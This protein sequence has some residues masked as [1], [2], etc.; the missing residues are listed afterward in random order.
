MSLSKQLCALPFKWTT[1]TSFK[2]KWHFRENE[3]SFHFFLIFLLSFL[4]LPLL[5]LMLLPVLLLLLPVLLL[6]P[7][8]LLSLLLLR[9]SST[10]SRA[11]QCQKLPI[12]AA[13]TEMVC[14]HSSVKNMFK[15]TQ[16]CFSLHFY[17]TPTKKVCERNNGILQARFSRAI[18][19]KN[20]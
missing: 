4:L 20:T 14:R 5:L 16:K 13:K 7:V 2:E 9:L 11:S 1:N 15:V 6:F 19:K 17:S 3:N 10:L 12:S 8:L 18:V